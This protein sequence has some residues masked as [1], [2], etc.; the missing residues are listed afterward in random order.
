[1]VLNSLLLVHPY[2]GTFKNLNGI[3]AR[4]LNKITVLDKGVIYPVIAISPDILSDDLHTTFE[5][6]FKKGLRTPFPEKVLHEYLDLLRQCTA[7]GTYFPGN[8]GTCPVC[9][10]KMVVVVQKPVVSTKDIEV[11]EL[12]RVNGDVLYTR[13]VGEAVRVLALEKG[14]VVYYEKYGHL[15]QTRKELFSFVRGS[16]FEMT[17]TH[18]FVNHP[19]SAEILVFDLSTGK[20]LG[21]LET[22][23]FVQNRKAAFRASNEYLFRID[24]GNLKF[25]KFQNGTFE[26]QVLRRVMEDQ[27]WFWVDEDAEN[28]SVFGLFQVIRQQMFWMV[29]DGKFYDVDIPQ[30]ETGEVVLDISA[31]FSSRGACLLR[32]TQVA[33][34]TYLR[35]DLIDEN[36]KVIFSTRMEEANHPNPSVHGQAYATGLILHPTDLGIMQ[37]VLQTGKTK[38]FPA[39]K[40][41]VDGGDSL[42]RFGGSILASKQ[43]R[44]LQ[45]TMK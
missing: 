31:R 43:D 14:R 29:R 44:V 16:K 42:I 9:S 10:V 18:L 45:I 27:T 25:G 22:E 37:E 23:I 1:M 24:S 33:G 20:L 13:V 6:Y 32:K 12:I 3:P 7:C 28:P 34:K 35:Q 40:G 17:Q 19:G 38:I 2:G 36:G 15:P 11:I 4:A 41:F 8:R 30:L 26:E 5:G 21:K 39:T